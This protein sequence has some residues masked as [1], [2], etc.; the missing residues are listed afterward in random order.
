MPGWADTP[1]PT[2]HQQRVPGPHAF[3]VRFGAVRPTR[4]DRSR[5]RPTIRPRARR[6]LRP[7]HPAPRSWRSRYA[8]CSGGET[9]WSIA[10]IAVL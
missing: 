10:V 2:W 1:S 7:P 4:S 5:N 8:P 3:A 9:A 6:R